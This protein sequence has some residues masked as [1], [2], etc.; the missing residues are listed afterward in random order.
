[1]GG[2]CSVRIFIAH[3]CAHVMPRF[4]VVFK[5]PIPPVLHDMKIAKYIKNQSSPD[6]FPIILAQCLFSTET[7]QKKGVALF[8]LALCKKYPAQTDFI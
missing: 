7:I 8:K 2:I 4:L 3:R 6:R 1:M 5:A